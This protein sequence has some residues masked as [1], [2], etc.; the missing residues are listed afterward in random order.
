VSKIENIR[1]LIPRDKHDLDRVGQLENQPLDHLRV[2][3]PELLKWL[4]DGNWPISQPIEDILKKF[5]YELLPYIR[6]ILN[7]NDVGW[8]YFLLEGLVRKLPNGVLRELEPD[9]RRIINSPTKDE[10]TEEV[11]EIAIELIE[12]L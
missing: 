5:S 7:S 9:L 11:D 12:R 10:K 3:L 4:Q 6:E 8:K 1:D 2:I